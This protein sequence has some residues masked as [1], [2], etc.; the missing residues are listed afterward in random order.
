LLALRENIFYRREKKEEAQ[1]SAEVF[2][3]SQNLICESLLCSKASQRL[4][5]AILCEKIFLPV[6]E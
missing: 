1:R 2:F 3:E 6:F 4:L 5:S